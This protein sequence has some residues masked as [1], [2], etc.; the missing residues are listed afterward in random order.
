[1]VLFMQAFH[2]Y[3]KLDQT[4]L[5]GLRAHSIDELLTGIRS[6]PD[7]SIYYHTHRFLHQHHFLSPE[8]PNDF[9]YW[10]TTILGDETL[11]ELLWSVDTIRFNDISGLR[12]ALIAIL[13]RYLAAKARSIECETGEEFHFMKS[14]SFVVPTRRTLLRRSVLMGTLAVAVSRP[15][16]ILAQGPSA[17]RGAGVSARLGPDADAASIDRAASA[18]PAFRA[19]STRRRS[20]ARSALG[21]RPRRPG[22]G[23]RLARAPRA[24]R[25]HGRAPRGRSPR[26]HA[27]AVPPGAP[28]RSAAQPAAPPVDGNPRRSAPPPVPAGTMNSTVL[29]GSHA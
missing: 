2:F 5:L 4:L 16:L 15:S 27:R 6:V 18:R 8:P 22:P 28:Q 19:P 29:V 11:G 10:V 20:S 1:M 13:D 9:A 14:R 24:P 7:A 25:D 3:T 12:E 21:E 23:S 17:A 26:A